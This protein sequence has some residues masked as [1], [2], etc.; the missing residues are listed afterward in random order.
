MAIFGTGRGR[1]RA[2][3]REVAGR[4]GCSG[5]AGLWIT[6][7]LVTAACLPLLLIGPQSGD[8][9][10]FNI[11]W[12]TGFAG[13][14]AA[15]TPYQRWLPDLNGGAGSPVFFFYGPVAYYITSL[16]FLG[17]RGCDPTIRLGI[18]EWL[19]VLAS[20]WPGTFRQL[21]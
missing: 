19:I 18:G 17:C 21:R 12:S 6:V 15:G 3:W 4:S 13:Q 9:F 14:L 11:N 5:V 20:Q 1:R 16:G 2:A 8:S 10:E 7:A